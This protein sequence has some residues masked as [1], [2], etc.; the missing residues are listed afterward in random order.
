MMTRRAAV[1]A[2]LAASATAAA[3]NCNRGAI[4]GHAGQRSAATTVVVVRFAAETAGVYATSVATV[5][6]TVSALSAS[7]DKA[8]D[9]GAGR[10]IEFRH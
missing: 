9:G 4:D 10:D 1:L 3:S 6:T 7:A 5:S 2:G 8:R